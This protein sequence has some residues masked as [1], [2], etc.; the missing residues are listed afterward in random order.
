MLQHLALHLNE[1]VFPRGMHDFQDKFASAGRGQMKIVVILAWKRLGGD[2]EAE[3][4]ASQ[5]R[6]F[7]FG[8]R[9]GYARFGNHAQ[10]LIRKD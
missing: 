4:F 6:S 7:R 3:D 1:G 5:P 8:D 2:I 10:N 9:L